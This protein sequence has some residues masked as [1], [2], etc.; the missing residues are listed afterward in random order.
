MIRER[1]DAREAELVPGAW[2]F[3]DAIVLRRGNTPERIETMQIRSEPGSD[4]RGGAVHRS[5]DHLDLRS[6]AQDRRLPL[7]RLERKR[8]RNA[9]PFTSGLPLLLVAMTL[10]AATVTMRFARM[11]QPIYIILG[12][13]LA[14]FLLYVLTAVMRAFGGAGIVPPLMAAWLPVLLAGF[15]G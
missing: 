7:L 6:A 1:I 2:E 4:L 12:G 15:M 5:R 8:L 3:R 11:G 10:I 13:I 14:G 9:F